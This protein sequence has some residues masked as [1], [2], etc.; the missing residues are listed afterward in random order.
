V[1]DTG[2][3]LGRTMGDV[4]VNNT[5]SNSLKSIGLHEFGRGFEEKENNKGIEEEH[6]KKYFRKKNRNRNSRSLYSPNPPISWFA[7]FPL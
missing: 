4:F 2:G 7:P 5:G 6:R 3:R 1:L